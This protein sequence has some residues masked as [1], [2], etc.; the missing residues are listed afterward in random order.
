MN[1]PLIAPFGHRHRVI[2]P[3]KS[4]RRQTKRRLLIFKREAIEVWYGT[5]MACRLQDSGTR[6]NNFSS[7][8]RAEYEEWYQMYQAFS[9]K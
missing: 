7:L 4:R 6:H 2:A 3:H 8:K 5:S 9:E 1:S